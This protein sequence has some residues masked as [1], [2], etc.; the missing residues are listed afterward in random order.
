MLGP[1]WGCWAG[2]KEEW[3]ILV[4]AGMGSQKLHAEGCP[5]KVKGELGSWDSVSLG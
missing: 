3:V 1:S 2:L 4:Q 5:A